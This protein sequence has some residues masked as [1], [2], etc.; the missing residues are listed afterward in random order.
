MKLFMKPF[1]LVAISTGLAVLAAA[2][3]CPARGEVREASNVLY[4]YNAAQETSIACTALVAKAEPSQFSPEPDNITTPKP[5][6]SAAAIVLKL[7]TQRTNVGSATRAYLYDQVYK[8]LYKICPPS[9]GAC[10]QDTAKFKVLHPPENGATVSYPEDLTVW[11]ENSKWDSNEV[12]YRLMVGIVAGSFERGT[13]T[14]GNCYTAKDYR[15]GE[16]EGVDAEFEFCNSVNVVAVKLPGGYHMKVHFTSSSTRGEMDCTK[17]IGHAQGYV[18][19]LQKE[20]EQALGRGDLY[21]DGGC[22]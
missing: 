17:V 4:D 8:A 5:P 14:K 3:P 13:Y 7:G 18:D 21:V 16:R 22:V 12:I 1:N 10:N 6:P 19:T 2:T 9:R 11:V 15:K 20:I